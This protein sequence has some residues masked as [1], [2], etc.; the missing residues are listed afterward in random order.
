MAVWQFGFSLV[1]EKRLT[2]I[3][4]CIPVN[5]FNAEVCEGSKKIKDND[6]KTFR[7][8]GNVGI[9]ASELITNIDKIL[10]RAYWVNSITFYYWKSKIPNQD[11]DVSLFIKENDENIV[12]E[13]SF[14]C[15]R[16]SESN[17]FLVEMLELG[18][19]YNCMVLD[20]RGNLLIP[21]IGKILDHLN[22][23]SSKSSE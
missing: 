9:S 8:W 3:F 17:Q 19:K 14:R 2:E 4:D 13:L 7:E 11:N 22:N 16:R 5:I 18:K 20:E 15:D 21:E 12:T 6:L 23:A 1:P 10:N